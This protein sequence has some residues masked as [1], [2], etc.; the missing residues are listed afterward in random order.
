MVEREAAPFHFAAPEG[1]DMI[2][3]AAVLTRARLGASRTS[4]CG[5]APLAR[6]R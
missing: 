4:R 6:L 5:L 3:D 2:V 1:L